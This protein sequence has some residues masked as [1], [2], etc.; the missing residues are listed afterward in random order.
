MNRFHVLT[1]APGTGKTAILDALGDD[2]TV[3]PEPARRVLAEW[4]AAGNPLPARMEARLMVRRMT[5][6]AIDDHAEAGRE[7]GPVLFD[8]GV[9][10]SVA[11]ARHLGL[12]A[13]EAFRAAASHAYNRRVLL[14][15]PWREIYATDDERTMSFKDVE[16]FHE[17]VVRTYLDAG[18]DLVVVPDAPLAERVEF[19]RRH[20]GVED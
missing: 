17:A 5:E 11:Y 8:R 10:D 1:G 13:D 19:V 6:L 4:R 20:I 16:R 12:D 18:Y 7:S 15:T 14:T 3:M 2:F 9:V